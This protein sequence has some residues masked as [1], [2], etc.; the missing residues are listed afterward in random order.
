MFFL[1]LSALPTPTPVHS[2]SESRGWTAPLYLCRALTVSPLHLRGR[3]HQLAAGSLCIQ[4]S[5]RE[6]PLPELPGS[7]SVSQ[8]TSVHRRGSN[9]TDP[10]K[11]KA[12]GSQS[13][14][15]IELSVMEEKFCICVVQYGSH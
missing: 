15:P 8:V 5:Q 7:F 10:P 11:R 12:L 3:S 6:L 4:L 9:N 2:P 1:P 14:C 13:G